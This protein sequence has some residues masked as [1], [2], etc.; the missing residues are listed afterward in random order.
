MGKHKGKPARESG[1]DAKDENGNSKGWSKLT[2]AEK[3]KEFDASL[4]DPSGY[5]TRN[6]SDQNQGRNGRRTKHGKK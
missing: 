1:T 4:K 5:A 2:G 6:F 3:G